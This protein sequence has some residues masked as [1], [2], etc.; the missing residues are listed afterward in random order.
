MSIEETLLYLANN[1][2]TFEYIFV[3]FILSI[4]GLSLPIPYTFIIVSNVYVFGWTGFFIVILSVPFGSLIT[5]YYIKKF[6][7][8]I[9][10]I[11]FFHKI[12]NN[13]LINKIEFHN[14]IY[15]LLVTRAT[16]PFFLVSAIYSLTNISLKKYL[17]TTV[18]GTFSNILLVSFIVNNIRDTIINYNNFVISWKDPRFIFPLIVL[19]LL[20][21]LGKKM[22]IK[23]FEDKN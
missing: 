11:K 9:K 7:Y 4:I 21:Y 13:K 20:V 14:N 16:L 15:V 5:F 3:F 8:Y 10:K 12:Y 2:F 23:I 17:Y 6:S 22:N 1:N 19:I 18:I